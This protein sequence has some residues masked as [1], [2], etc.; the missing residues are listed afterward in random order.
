MADATNSGRCNPPEFFV[1]DLDKL[2]IKRIVLTCNL[3]ENLHEK[4]K[5]LVM[6]AIKIWGLNTKMISSSCQILMEEILFN[7]HHYIYKPP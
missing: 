1:Q 6:N 7:N 3:H 2:R 5:I 4:S